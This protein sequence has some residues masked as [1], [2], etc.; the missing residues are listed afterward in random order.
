MIIN[1]KEKISQFKVK[2]QVDFITYR[3]N[4]Q[5]KGASVNLYQ[6]LKTSYLI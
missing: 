6:S 2:E 4:Y 3:G 1:I 5:K